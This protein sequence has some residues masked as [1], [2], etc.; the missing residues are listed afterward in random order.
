MKKVYL[1]RGNDGKYKIGV[2]K[3][4][5]KRIKPIQTGNP[6]QLTIVEVYESNNAYKI[7]TALHN[8][9]AY[10]RNTGEWFDLSISDEIT[11]IENC[12]NIDN[13]I[14]ILKKMENYFI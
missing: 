11:F 10:T 1:I 5:T 6:D 14:N 4:P 9:Y 3:T 13:G 2:S 8:K 7:E 12:R